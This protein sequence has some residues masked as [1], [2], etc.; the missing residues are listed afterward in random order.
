M[1]LLCLFQTNGTIDTMSQTLR[2]ERENNPVILDK[3]EQ[4]VLNCPER[5]S[6]G[7]EVRPCDEKYVL[8]MLKAIQPN[9]MFI[10]IHDI[11]SNFDQHFT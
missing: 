10:F 7:K 1:L 6:I 8:A 4:M 3:S 2:S 11:F 9:V 5:T